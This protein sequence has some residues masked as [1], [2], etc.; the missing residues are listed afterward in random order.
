MAIPGSNLGYVNP[1]AGEFGGAPF[2]EMNC[3]P[4][5]SKAS[6]AILPEKIAPTGE[7]LA[8]TA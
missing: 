8:A 6:S 7:Q 5:H 1:G 3:R 4:G 2:L